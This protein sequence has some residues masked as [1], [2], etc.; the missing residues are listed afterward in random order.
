MSGAEATK[1]KWLAPAV[2][3]SREMCFQQGKAYVYE[4][5]DE[6]GIII[7]E[8]PNGVVDRKCMRTLTKTRRWP[9]GCLE[10]GPAEV[11]WDFPHWPKSTGPER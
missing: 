2:E 11:E 8:W 7:T 5:R 4:P 3:D 9:D 6:P 1:K 10:S